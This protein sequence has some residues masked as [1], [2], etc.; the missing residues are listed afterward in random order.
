M[1]DIKELGCRG[2]SVV[3]RCGGLWFVLVGLDDDEVSLKTRWYT[4]LQCGLC[5]KDGCLGVVDYY[6]DTVVGMARIER[7]VAAS[8]LDNAVDNDVS[9]DGSVK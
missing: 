8:C 9:L 5:Y 3:V 6:L 2:S 7:N 4:M 1:E